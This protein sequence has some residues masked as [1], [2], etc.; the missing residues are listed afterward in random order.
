M[1]VFLRLNFLYGIA[2][3]SKNE[4]GK[5]NK[6]AETSLRE[7]IASIIYWQKFE[8]KSSLDKNQL[9]LLQ[10]VWL[11]TKEQTSKL[12]GSNL[13]EKLISVSNK[14]SRSFG[15]F[16]TSPP[17][18]VTLFSSQT[19]LLSSQNP[20]PPSFMS[21]PLVWVGLVKMFFEFEVNVLMGRLY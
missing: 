2:S 21:D 7:K 17:P 3:S 16:L 18:T 1:L 15:Q 13:F 14:I 5:S 10:G 20:W 12:V 9:F 6:I 8:K 19:L 11:T 4:S